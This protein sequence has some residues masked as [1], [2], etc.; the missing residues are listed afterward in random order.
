VGAEKSRREVKRDPRA[1]GGSLVGG[2]TVSGPGAEDR[3]LRRDA[4]GRPVLGSGPTLRV[5][6]VDRDVGAIGEVDHRF[7]EA[8]THCFVAVP[9]TCPALCDATSHHPC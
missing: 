2:V 3:S 5:R 7:H 9:T 4:P 6:S 1:I 8:T